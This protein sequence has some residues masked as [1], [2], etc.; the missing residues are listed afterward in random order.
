MKRLYTS[1][2]DKMNTEKMIVIILTGMICI[3]FPSFILGIIMAEDCV[4]MESFERHCCKFTSNFTTTNSRLAS[5]YG[6]V[7]GQL[8]NS[9]TNITLRYPPSKY[10]ML[11]VNTETSMNKWYEDR[12]GTIFKCYVENDIGV[13]DRCEYALPIVGSILGI[14]CVITGIVGCVIYKKNETPR[15]VRQRNDGGTVPNIVT[16]YNN[17]LFPQLS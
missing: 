17:P 4:S 2:N 7:N 5:V 16:K 13:S 10:W 11:Y 15:R 6:E 9:D 14:A 12:V 1:T 3:G 8:C